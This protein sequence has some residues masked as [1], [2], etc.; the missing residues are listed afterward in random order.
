MK[1]TTTTG[2]ATGR[3]P[4]ALMYGCCR[5]GIGRSMACLRCQRWLRHHRVF[6]KRRSEIGGS[7]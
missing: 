5:C 6:V 1:R 7:Q 4:G 3:R 2:A